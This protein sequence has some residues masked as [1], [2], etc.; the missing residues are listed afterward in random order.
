MRRTDPEMYELEQSDHELERATFALS[1]Q[2]R[3]APMEQRAELKKQ[4]QEHVTKHF[5]VR[6]KKRQLQLSRAEKELQR[7]RE[8]LKRRDEAKEQIVTRRVSEITGE[9][10]ELDF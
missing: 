7:L 1:N 8:E 6:Q 9:R 3:N 2:F 10:G 5:E 4:I